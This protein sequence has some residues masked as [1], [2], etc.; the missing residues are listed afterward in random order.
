MENRGSPERAPIDSPTTL[1]AFGTGFRVTGPA[2]IADAALTALADRT[3][4]CPVAGEPDVTYEIRTGAE[5]M[6]LRHDEVEVAHVGYAATGVEA[7]DLIGDDIHQQIAHRSEELLFVHAGAVAWR[8]LAIA[9]PG[10]SHSGKS[11]LVAAL[12][13]AGA[14]YLS[15]EFAA[16]DRGGLVHPYPRKLSIRSTD[17]EP[18]AVDVA[19]L[20]GLAARHPA[21]LAL[22]VSTRFEPDATWDPTSLTGSRALLPLID[23]SVVA[24]TRSAHTM[25]TVAGLGHTV[26]TLVG[27]RGEADGVAS[28]I[29]DFVELLADG[30]TTRDA[31][32]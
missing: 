29:L 14:E 27:L 15:D 16:L 7:A 22:V 12:V 13:R 19:E 31:A 32:R 23:N 21:P 3:A 20:G 28:A 11:T 9:I 4:L 5:L 24:Q 30:T 2:A 25:S 1:S 6:I 17:G 10:R 26:T 18:R 8:G